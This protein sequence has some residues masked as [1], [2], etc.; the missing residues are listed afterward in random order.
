MFHMKH[1]HSGIIFTKKAPS[2]G[3]GRPACGQGIGRRRRVVGL[4]AIA[5][6]LHRYVFHSDTFRYSELSPLPPFQRK[7]AN[8]SD[9]TTRGMFPV[10]HVDSGITSSVLA[11][12]SGEL[13][14]A[15]G[16]AQAV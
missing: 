7:R 2:S 10:K 6:R 8:A 12:L 4:A 11:P 16:A 13:P 15:E 3:K 5:G 14:K 9:E 1:E